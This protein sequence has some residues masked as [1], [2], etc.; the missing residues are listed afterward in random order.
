MYQ[1]SHIIILN[2]LFEAQPW[3]HQVRFPC[4]NRLFESFI[5]SCIIFLSGLTFIFKSLKRYQERCFKKKNRTWTDSKY[6]DALLKSFPGYE[7][8]RSHLQSS[9]KSYQSNRPTVTNNQRALL[10]S[11]VC[12]NT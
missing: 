3:L 7:C 9:N 1:I 12:T 8:S 6:Q 5:T 4:R 10:I 11:L 2:C